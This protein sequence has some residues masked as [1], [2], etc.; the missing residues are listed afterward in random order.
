[1][2]MRNNDYIEVVLTY[3]NVICLTLCQANISFKKDEN[4][5]QS[6]EKHFDF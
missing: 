6:F 2:F 1:M 5:T 3:L 4:K